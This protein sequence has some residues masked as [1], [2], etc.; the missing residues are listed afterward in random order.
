MTANLLGI[1]IVTLAQSDWHL[2]APGRN[3]QRGVTAVIV[4]ALLVVAGAA[5]WP[6]LVVDHGG[7][8]NGFRPIAGLVSAGLLT[9]VTGRAVPGGTGRSRI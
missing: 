6:W 5:L 9:S 4:A 3:R 8:V 2:V 1:V 7:P